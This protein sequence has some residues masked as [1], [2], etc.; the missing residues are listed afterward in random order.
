MGKVQLSRGLDALSLLL[1]FALSVLYPVVQGNAQIIIEFP[2]PT[3]SSYPYGI[4]V[5]NGLVYLTE[6]AGND[7]GR[8]D[9]DHTFF[10]PHTE[11]WFTWYDLVN[12]QV[13]N[14]HF[15]NPGASTATI[16]I[17]IA[18]VQKDSFAL[19][20]GQS[21]Y[22]NYAGVMGGPVH[23]VSDRPIWCTQR[24]VGWG[25]FKEASGLPGDMAATEIY[26]TW[27]DMKFAGSDAI[28]ILNPSSTQTAH[29]D[30]YIAG[31]KKSSTPIAIDPGEAT[32]VTYPGE[33]G[34]P[35][36]IV[37][38]VP[39]FSTQRVVGWSDFDEVVGMPSWYVFGENWFNWYD[40]AGASI[41]NVHFINPGS[42]TANI[43]VYVSGVL[44]G[45]YALDPGSANYISYP[46]LTGG[47]VRVVSDQP[48]WCT[49]RIVGWSG[50]KEEFSVVGSGW[51][52]K[53]YW[54]WPLTIIEPDG[55]WVCDI[56]TGGIDEQATEIAAFLLPRGY[57]PPLMSGQ[58]VL[59][60]E[61][62][63]NALAWVNVTRMPGDIGFR[64][65]PTR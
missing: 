18:G 43:Q 37:S 17:Y 64:H 65:T 57:D 47:P 5:Y 36:R 10:H 54:A 51:W 19:A 60:P 20:V 44:R 24:I 55:S 1:A 61:L 6:E 25:S 58:S 22:R 9:L 7:I 53:P 23:I 2:I 63:G 46:S 41:D 31:V 12:A 56:V 8:L 59:P 21:T 27:Y 62:N 16:T 42:S 48:I 40:S 14:I 11:L 32:Y 45:S 39:I 15:V 33:I 29:V 26:Y 49:Q 52:T 28:H 3:A 13:D 38:D 50:F 34:G 30:V 35:V 4:T